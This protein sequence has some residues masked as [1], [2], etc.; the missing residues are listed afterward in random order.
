MCPLYVWEDEETKVQVV[1]VRTVQDI[2]V[3]P[4][5]EE[6]NIEQPKWRR[7]LCASAFKRGSNWSGSKGNW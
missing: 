6:A 4:T 1:V 7:L 3:P 2:E 5:K